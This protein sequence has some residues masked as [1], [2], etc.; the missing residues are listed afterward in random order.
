MQPQLSPKKYIQTR[1]RTLPIYKCFVNKD[2]ET[3]SMANVFVMRRHVNGNLTVGVY[4]VDLLCLGV[5]DT[6][7]F[8][9]QDEHEL[10]EKISTPIFMEID[11]NL[12]H[13]I[14]YAGHDFAMDYDIHPHKDF[15][16]TRHILEADT[17]AIPLIEIQTG[18]AEGLPHLLVNSAGQY[19][20]ALAKLRKNA[21]EGNYHYT[22]VA[23]F[24]DEKEEDDMP[25][26]MDLLD[27]YEEGAIS[28]QAAMHIS[29]DELLDEDKLQKRTPD[30]RLTLEIEVLLRML[31]IQD[32][33]AFDFY[34][35]A[36]TPEYRHYLEHPAE[37]LC[38]YERVPEADE[39][40]YDAAKRLQILDELVAVID[41]TDKLPGKVH[42]LLARY[43]DDMRTATIIFTTIL[44]TTAPAG[45]E[46][47]VAKLRGFGAQYPYARLT[48][49]MAALLRPD[50]VSQDDFSDI[51]QSAEIR[52]VFPGYESF[53]IAELGIYWLIRML[54]AVRA[55]DITPALRY[56][57]LV[58]ATEISGIQL[59]FAQSE[60]YDLLEHTVTQHLQEAENKA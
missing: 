24:D 22:V 55:Q 52:E 19:S 57:A 33:D 28:M 49:A 23:E 12:A 2:W 40:E 42:E 50:V 56:Y 3:S 4:L 35:L 51:Y 38:G 36:D 45:Q 44:V 10:M 58:A 20:E 7:F 11:Y 15:T 17:D 16:L 34:A 60:F 9:N 29:M 13:N 46:E 8:F 25:D 43:G 54:I 30:E 37:V 27:D 53:H 5:K 31:R 6:F 48:L 14:V 47:L 26:E 32:P 18:D 41:K 59:L 39:D 21:G 1:A